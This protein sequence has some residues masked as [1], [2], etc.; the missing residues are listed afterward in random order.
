MG[1]NSL[2]FMLMLFLGC[3][4]HASAQFRVGVEAGYLNSN[5][6]LDGGPKHSTPGFLA[7]VIASYT[8]RDIG[9]LESGLSLQQ[10]GVHFEPLYVA[11]LPPFINDVQMKAYYLDLPLLLGLKF[12]ITKEL[13]ILPKAGGFFSYGLHAEAAFA[14]EHV[15]EGGQIIEGGAFAVKYN[16]FTTLEHVG[17]T[18]DPTLVRVGYYRFDVG[19]QAGLDVMWKQYALRGAYKQGLTPHDFFTYRMNCRTFSVS[20]A[21]Y[22]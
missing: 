8:I 21:Y 2:F 19:F 22:F 20:L 5:F 4:I 17:P 11:A 7:G 12:N 6:A 10:K 18:L 9:W 13:L 16:P 1:K 15:D 3:G 14:G